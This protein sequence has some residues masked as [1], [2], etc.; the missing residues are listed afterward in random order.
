[1]QIHGR[2]RRELNPSGEIGEW[3]E[4]ASLHNTSNLQGTSRLHAYQVHGE[5]DNKSDRQVRERLQTK[6]ATI[7]GALKARKKNSKERRRSYD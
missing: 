4:D 3:I 7:T 2:I 5:S 6:Q 1:M